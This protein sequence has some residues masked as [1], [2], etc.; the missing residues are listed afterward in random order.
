M[1]KLKLQQKKPIK[2]IF[3]RYPANTTDITKYN[4]EIKKKKIRNIL[5]NSKTNIELNNHGV[6]KIPCKECGIYLGQTKMD[7]LTSEE[8]NKM[9]SEKLTQCQEQFS[10]H[11][12]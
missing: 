4:I 10:F 12:L 1:S 6:N 2:R 7:A 8:Y 3:N 5:R 11:R 9:R